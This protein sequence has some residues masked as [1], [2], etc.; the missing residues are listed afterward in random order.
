MDRTQGNRRKVA[1]IRLRSK[2]IRITWANPEG[3]G[4]CSLDQSFQTID[5][6]SIKKRARC[7]DRALSFYW[8]NWQGILAFA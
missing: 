5:K 6:Q 4:F 7:N 8:F 3:E 2:G 1:K